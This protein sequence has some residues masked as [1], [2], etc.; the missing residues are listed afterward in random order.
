M[1]WAA[2]SLVSIVGLPMVVVAL[3]DTGLT[4]GHED[5]QGYIDDVH[6]FNFVDYNGN[7][8]FHAPFKL[9]SREFHLP[10]VRLNDRGIAGAAGRN[11][12]VKLMVVKALTASGGY[13]SDAISAV[14]Y[15]M[16]MGAQIS[17][18][19][20]GGHSLQTANANFEGEE[21]ING[22]FLV[23]LGCFAVAGPPRESQS[24][25]Q[26]LWCCETPPKH[27]KYESPVKLQ[28]LL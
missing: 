6:G 17:S 23:F 26:A 24:L 20:W 27:P 9:R 19:S 5:L 12:Y 2:L 18:N 15:A 14:N 4:F 16:A 25:Q 21:A 3:I 22:G 1:D 7:P 28:G 13:K 8:V 10:A 11:Q